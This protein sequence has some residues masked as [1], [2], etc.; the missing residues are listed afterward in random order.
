LNERFVSAQIKQMDIVSLPHTQ[1]QLYA[2]SL[3]YPNAYDFNRPH[4]HDYFEIIFIEK[5]GGHQL[6]DFDRFELKKGEVY[7]VY[8]GQ[9]HLLRREGAQ[10]LVL[11]FR[12]E[13]FDY[14][15]PLKHQLLYFKKP[16]ILLPEVVFDHLYHIAIQIKSLSNQRELT[17]FTS[18][19]PISYLNTI[20]LHLVEANYESSA[21]EQSHFAGQFL[22]MLSTNIRDKRKVKDFAEMLSM[23]PER[24][25]DLTKN[26]FG[27]PPLKLIHE[28]LILEIKRLIILHQLTLKE[29]AFELNFESQANFSA[30][31]KSALGVTPT[32]LQKDLVNQLS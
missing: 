26:T 6:I 16:Q 22:H 8:P 30:F 23:T 12:K 4:R 19:I 25:T 24:L 15:L 31:I 2:E 28:E 21:E 5:G 3:D 13:I 11:Q 29:I 18:F 7:V 1:K 20:L 17:P 14:L 9:V 10:G 32:E 27:K